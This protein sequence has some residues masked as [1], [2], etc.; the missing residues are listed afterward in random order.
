MVTN[1]SRV[2]TRPDR[3]QIDRNES[4]Q[5]L[6]DFIKARMADNTVYGVAAILIMKDGSNFTFVSPIYDN[7]KMLGAIDFLKYETTKRYSEDTKNIREF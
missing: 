6:V 5:E 1:V 3:E 4:A 7:L 2:K